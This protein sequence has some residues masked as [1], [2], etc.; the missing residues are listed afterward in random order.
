MRDSG[1][2]DASSVPLLKHLWMAGK[3][4]PFSFLC[5]LVCVVQAQQS[6]GLVFQAKEAPDLDSTNGEGISLRELMKSAIE[7]RMTGPAPGDH[8]TP[9][10]AYRRVL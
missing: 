7:D 1:P 8:A 5:S 10:L 6:G 9:S 2:R 4:W 3:G